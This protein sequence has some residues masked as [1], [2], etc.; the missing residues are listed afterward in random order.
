MRQEVFFSMAID[1]VNPY[2]MAV[3][4]FDEA[5]DRLGRDKGLRAD[6]ARCRG[7]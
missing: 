6:A 4:Q 3:A 2:D 1:I 7:Q 5:A